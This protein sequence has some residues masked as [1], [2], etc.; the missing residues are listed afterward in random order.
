MSQEKVEIVRSIYEAINRG[1]PDAAFRDQDPNVELTT[2]ERGFNTGT[3]RG[4]EE[5]QR[6]WLELR[7]PFEAVSTE[8]E[9]LVEIGDQV[10][11]IVRVR[12]RPKGST[13]ELEFRNGHLWMFREGKV[14][15]VRMFPEPE[16]AL[17]AVGLRE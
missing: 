16:K 5:I 7:S 14:I 15:S 9:K 17:E 11:A 3:Y 6:Y 13:A 2:P 12:M 10:V 8:P 1:D 4:R